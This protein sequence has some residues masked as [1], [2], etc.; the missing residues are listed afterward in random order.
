MCQYFFLLLGETKAEPAGMSLWIEEGS[1]W[2]GT[3]T[4]FI[5][6]C[7]G[8]LCNAHFSPISPLGTWSEHPRASPWEDPGCMGHRGR[9]GA[10]AEPQHGADRLTLGPT[11]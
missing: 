11:V 7:P 3:D 1:E 5:L 6:Q 4:F 9:A 8:K 10:Q 2:V